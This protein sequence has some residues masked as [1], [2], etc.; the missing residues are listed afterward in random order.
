MSGQGALKSEASQLSRQGGQLQSYLANGTLPP[1]VQAG[2]T[3]AADAQKA[4]IR[5][6]YAASGSSGSSAEA[7]DLA[8]VDQ[9]AQAQG[10]QIAMQLLTSGIS[11]SGLASGIYENIA[12]QSLQEDKDLGSAFGSLASAL[13]GGG[14]TTNKG[15]ITFG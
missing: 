1:G 5:S 4:S 7:A 3:Q 15:T 11:E 10:A 2:I 13:S 14:G 12:N 8:A 9:Q 6:R